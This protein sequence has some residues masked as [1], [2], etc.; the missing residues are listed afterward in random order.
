L[1]VTIFF[2]AEKMMSQN[3]RAGMVNIEQVPENYIQFKDPPEKILAARVGRD[4]TEITGDCDG[5]HSERRHDSVTLFRS[6]AV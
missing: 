1:G 6:E 4:V 2:I 3:R 5:R